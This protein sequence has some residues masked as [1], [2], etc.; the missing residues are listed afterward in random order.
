MDFL[1]EYQQFWYTIAKNQVTQTYQF[2]LD[3]QHFEVRPELFREMLQITPK[4]PNQ[5]FIEPLPH[6]EL[7]SFIKQL[8]YKGSLELVSEMYIDL[9]YQPW[10]TFL[11][12]S[13]GVC[14]GSLQFQIDSR[15]SS[16]KRKE[17][18]PYPRF[19]KVIINHF[20]SK[21][22]T[23]SKRHGSFLHTIK[24]DSVLG[25]LKFMSKEEER[26]KY[27]MSIP[28]SMMNDEIKESAHYMTY[29]ALS[30]NIEAN[31]LK[32]GK[33]KGLMGKKKA[34][35]YVQKGKKKDVV[36]DAGK[37]KNAPRKKSSIT[38]DDNILPDPDEDLK[39]GESMSLTKAEIDEEECHIS[40]NDEIKADENKAEE[41]KTIED[42]TI[43]EPQV[44]DQTR[45][46]QTRGKQ[47]K[48]H[49]PETEVPNPSSNLTLSSAEYGNQFI[50]ENPNVS[51]NDTL[52]DTTEPE[53]QS[54]VDV[55]IH[56]EDSAV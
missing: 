32:V 24:Y 4:V 7:V 46:E 39:L 14:L 34:N 30:T 35:T 10:R 18:M 36:I 21:H 54:M 42:Q 5:E 2:Q 20:L 40:S 26:Q 43:E 45:M 6:D 29:L 23:L 13:I 41:E 52:K 3:N 49:V 8:G 19:T 50:N 55:P 11:N 53:I 48:V 25:K 33:G 27:G 16:A 51:I 22:D 9:M 38:A 44:D 56:Q 15:Q 47:A 28:D 31:I 12:I 17:Q 37:K 1:A